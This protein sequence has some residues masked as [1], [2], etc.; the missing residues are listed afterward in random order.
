MS[1]V[2]TFQNLFHIFTT[3]S[4]LPQQGFWVSLRAGPLSPKRKKDAMNSIEYQIN[5]LNNITPTQ[6]GLFICGR[7]EK[8][9]SV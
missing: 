6:Y 4:F 1:T 2:Y 3:A 5:R 9:F 7:S 8:G